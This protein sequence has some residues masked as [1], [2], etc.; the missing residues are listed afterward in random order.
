MSW[1]L[2]ILRSSDNS[3]YTG[4]TTNITNRVKVHNLGKGSKSLRGKLPIK[5]VYSETFA[6]RSEALKREYELKQL[7]KSQKERLLVTNELSS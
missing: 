2:Y 3:L 5:L 6:T 1:F 7:T 4:I